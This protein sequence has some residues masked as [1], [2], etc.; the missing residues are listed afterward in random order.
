MLV[1]HT[2]NGPWEEVPLYQPSAE[3]TERMLQRFPGLNGLNYEFWLHNF[4]IDGLL[5]FDMIQ[6]RPYKGGGIL[7]F[8]K[9][10]N[11]LSDS[12]W[13]RDNHTHLNITLYGHNRFKL[14]MQQPGAAKEL[15]DYIDSVICASI[16]WNAVGL[17]VASECSECGTTLT[18]DE[19]M[20]K[21]AMKVVA[22]TITEDPQI[23]R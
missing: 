11:A 22:K 9:S 15:A 8:V 5:A 18:M 3:A 4:F 17:A 23:L 1:Q 2:A 10:V 12:Q 13:R 21:E 20:R 16:P 7:G 19:E 14:R 6:Q